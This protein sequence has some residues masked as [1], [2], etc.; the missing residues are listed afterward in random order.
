VTA[1]VLAGSAFIAV[2][3]I[4]GVFGAL[5]LLVIAVWLGTKLSL[6]PSA[7][8]LERI[9]IRAAMAR[10]WSLT[11]RSFWRTFGVQA[12]VWVIL[13]TASQIISFP[14]SIIYS[15]A[16]TLIAPTGASSVNGTAVVVAI[17]SYV[18][19]IVISL[20]VSSITAVVQ[21]ATSA[22]LYLDLRMRREGLD[23]VLIRFVE[24][25]QAGASALNDP[26]VPTRQA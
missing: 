10:S 23:L 20:V 13:S 4:V 7:I 9:G 16:S 22:L 18:V 21:A 1:L 5:G 3:V 26:F 17:G 24:E 14:V 12:L 6:V 25:R 2:G 11:N 19:L 15:I 8:V